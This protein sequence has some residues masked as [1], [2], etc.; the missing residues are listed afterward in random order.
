M[1][2][3]L[4]DLPAERFIQEIRR[5]YA[6][7]EQIA[8][9]AVAKRLARGITEPGW[10]EKKLA[11]LHLL[12]RELQRDTAFLRRVPPEIE[13]QMQKA[14]EAGAG[15]GATWLKQANLLDPEASMAGQAGIKALVR[16]SALR[17][18]SANLQ[19][20]RSSLDV[21]RRAVS[22]AAPQVLTG[23]QTARQAAQAAVNNWAS[24]GITGFVDKAGR[25]WEI[26]SYAEMSVRTSVIRSQVQGHLDKL[27]AN[28][29]D[30]VYVSNHPEEC[31]LCRP[32]EGKVLSISGRSA[33]YPTVAQ[34]THAGLFHA[35]C[36]HA[37][38]AY[39]PGY[40]K[41]PDREQDL[42]DGK[43]SAQRYDERQRQRYLERQIRLWKRRE[44]AALTDTDAA[45]ARRKVRQWQGEMRDFIADT[46]RRRDYG[47]ESI[48]RAR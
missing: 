27:S 25:R 33:G 16:E 48:K 19:I 2:V 38:N 18:E 4:A 28:D 10:A 7:A 35:N 44:A 17:I 41:L 45:M 47:R 11:E 22:A 13:A 5:I 46:G 26:S 21:Y 29:V 24:K 39:L 34:A 6:E 37:V 36:T 42:G 43:T 1:A 40:T 31:P 32:W 14:Y 15:E 3:A 8:I 20:L 9:R 30:L 23:T 12:N